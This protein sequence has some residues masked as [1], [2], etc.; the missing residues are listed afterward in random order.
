MQ[1]S[2]V[3]LIPLGPRLG[4]VALL[5][6]EEILPGQSFLWPRGKTLRFRPR[7]PGVRG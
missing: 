4:F 7:G 3:F 1:Y 2:F 5:E 6:G